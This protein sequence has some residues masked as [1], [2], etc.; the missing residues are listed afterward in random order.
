MDDEVGGRRFGRGAV[1]GA[2][3]A[4]AV[5]GCVEGR[6]EGSGGGGMSLVSR[7]ADEFGS[8]LSFGGPRVYEGPLARWI[9]FR[10]GNDGGGRLFRSSSS[11]SES[12]GA[13]RFKVGTAGS[14]PFV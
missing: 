12:S 14:E 13:S 10:A 4:A 7:A 2:R 9:E 3:S 8:G 11:S 6:I 1:G 5:F